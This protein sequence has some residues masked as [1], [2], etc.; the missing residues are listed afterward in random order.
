MFETIEEKGKKSIFA[1]GFVTL[2][3][4][5]LG[6]HGSRD[7]NWAAKNTTEFHKCLSQ[8][9]DP[10]IGALKPPLLLYG[11]KYVTHDPDSIYPGSM[12]AKGDQKA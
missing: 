7:K 4:A 1:K 8:A 10:T 12:T 6:C 2:D 9:G 5:C 3:Y 11:R